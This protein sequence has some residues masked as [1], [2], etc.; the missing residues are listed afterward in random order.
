MGKYLSCLSSVKR[1]SYT[2]HEQDLE[3]SQTMN[4]RIHTSFLALTALALV[5][6]ISLAA[7]KVSAAPAPSYMLSSLPASDAVI[8]IDAQRLLTDSIPGALAGSP[9]LLARVNAKIDQFKERTNIDLRSFDSVA[10]GVRFI[11]HATGEDFKLVVLTQGRFDANAVL[12]A[13]LGAAKREGLHPQERS[14][15]GRTIYVL[16]RRQPEARQEETADNQERVD[17]Q[18][19]TT[20]TNDMALAV[21]DANTFAFGDLKSVQAA[22][23]IS[24]ERVSDDLVQLAT[25]TPQAV[26][27]FSGNVPD[28]LTERLA[29]DKEPIAQNFAAIRQ[30][31][32][33]ITTTGS[34]AEATV[35]LRA[36]T[37][38]QASEIVKAVN[39]LKLLASFDTKP[40]PAGDMSAITELIKSLT[41]TA[42]G[43]EVFLNLK[44]TQAQ[45]TSLARSL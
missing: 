14:F 16:S 3:R 31:Y 11:A 34:D 45:I 29:R 36:E 12:D 24:A 42:E 1:A 23:D 25:R 9:E 20:E 40:S 6:L 8:Y 32:G 33:S 15:D 43:N 35:T 17:H 13:A 7:Q 19:P 41:V 10:I 28:F 39:A 18:K 21:V 22:L 26:V 44:L 30:V 38:A 2:R 4:K 5:F 27:G 37:A